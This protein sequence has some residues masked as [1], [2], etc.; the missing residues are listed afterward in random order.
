[1]GRVKEAIMTVEDMFNEEFKKFEEMIKNALDE[2]RNNGC[3]NKKIVSKISMATCEGRL[4]AYARI[5]KELLGDESLMRKY[6]TALEKYAND[7]LDMLVEKEN[8]QDN[9]DEEDDFFLI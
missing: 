3:R 5:A 8:S 7:A 2:Y 6:E 9:E 1:M 4:Q